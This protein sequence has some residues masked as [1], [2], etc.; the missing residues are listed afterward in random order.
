MFLFHEKEPTVKMGKCWVANSLALLEK[1]P[2]TL[3]HLIELLLLLS[4]VVL[5]SIQSKSE[6]TKKSCLP[7]SVERKG[8]YLE[9]FI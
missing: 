4:L 5:T 1:D 3:D 8:E 2:Q 9:I 6:V 7:V